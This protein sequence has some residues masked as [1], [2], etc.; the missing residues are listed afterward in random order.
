M[1]P[2]Y[3]PLDGQE[4]LKWLLERIKKELEGNYMFGQSHAYH[5][6]SFHVNVELTTWSAEGAYPVNTSVADAV[7]EK[8]TAAPDDPILTKANSKINKKFKVN[9]PKPVLE[10]DRVRDEIGEPR[11][12]TE[13]VGDILVDAKVKKEKDATK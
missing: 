13:K 2:I 6:P 9:Q 8:L 11:Y 1:Q 12:T 5:N 10:P 4:L 7:A 3:H